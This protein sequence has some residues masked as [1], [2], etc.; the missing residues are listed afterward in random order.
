M[1]T[2]SGRGAI[3]E[4]TPEGLRFLWGGT[5]FDIKVMVTLPTKLRAEYEFMK[6]V[7]FNM[8]MQGPLELYDLDSSDEIYGFLDDVQRKGRS[9]VTYLVQYGPLHKLKV[10][11]DVLGDYDEL[12]SLKSTAALL[13]AV[14]EMS[15]YETKTALSAIEKEIKVRERIE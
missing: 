10:Q 13:E 15:I 12:T 11:W 7:L 6:A 8:Y 3:L 2:Y 5:A 9:L 1:T 14:A 4:E